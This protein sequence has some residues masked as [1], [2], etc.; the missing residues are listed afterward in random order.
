[1]EFER[2]KD[3]DLIVERIARWYAHRVW[4]I[5]PRDL[6][7]EGWI[8]ALEIQLDGVDQDYYRAYVYCS[9]SRRLSRYC[10]ELSSPLSDSKAGRHLKGMHSVEMDPKI[11]SSGRNPEEEALRR[12]AEYLLPVFR[13]DLKDRVTELYVAGSPVVDPDVIFAVLAVLVDGEKPAGV[14]AGVG[15]DVQVLYRTTEWVKDKARTDDTVR[16]LLANIRSRRRDTDD[17]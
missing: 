16:V 1:M 7:Q 6:R 3:V 11:R 5:D 4:W 14:A 10:W 17:Y 13:A 2:Q 9:V 12:E 8:C 15:L